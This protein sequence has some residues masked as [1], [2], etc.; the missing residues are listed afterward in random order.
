MAAG[1]YGKGFGAY[2]GKIM[3]LSLNEV[4]VNESNYAQNRA[5]DSSNVYALEGEIIDGPTD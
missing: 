4:D 3:D 2:D 5:A 1:R